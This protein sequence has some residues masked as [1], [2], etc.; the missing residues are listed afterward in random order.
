M[1]EWFASFLFIECLKE[2]SYIPSR[3]TQNN[4][5]WFQNIHEDELDYSVIPYR[6]N[7]RTSSLQNDQFLGLTYLSSI[8]YLNLF[9]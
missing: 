8:L 5:D 1:S 9:S 2:P 4:L 7:L 3:Q 6:E